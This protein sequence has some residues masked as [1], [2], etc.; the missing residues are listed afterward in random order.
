MDP[1]RVGV[2]GLGWWGGE[3]VRGGRASG[4]VDPVVCFAREEARRKGFA[5]EHRLRAA[6]SYQEVLADPDVEGVLIATPHS[7]HTELVTMAAS[8]GKHVFVEKPLT[9][10]VEDGRSC[11]TAADRAGVVLQVGHNR[12]RQPANRRIRQLIEDGSLGTPTLADANHSGPGGLRTAP[13]DWRSDPAERPLS[14]MTAYGVHVIDTFHYLIG[15]IARVIAMSTRLLDRTALDDASV[16]AFEFA[17]GAVGVLATSTVVPATTRV[18][19][20]GTGGAAWNEDDGQRLLVHPVGERAPS[21]EPVEP[22]DTIADE[23]AEFAGSVRTGSLPETGGRE[24]LLVVA[25]LEAAV[26]SAATGSAV[27]V[28][29]LGE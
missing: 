20:L 15:P 7:T 27:E 24:G 10:T 5:E 28:A 4:L 11:M 29:D 25:V 8:A 12:R 21:E 18:G 14:G 17:S 19:V 13:E 22:L 1:V 3:L 9:L 6:G 16:L 2:V 26:A 23:L